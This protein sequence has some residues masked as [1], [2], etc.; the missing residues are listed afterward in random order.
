MEQHVIRQIRKRDGRLVAFDEQKI[1]NAIYRAMSITGMN[2]LGQAQA[3]AKRVCNI[4]KAV[5]KSDKVPTVESVQDIVETTLMDEGFL[6]VAKRYII[7]RE[8]HQKMRSTE[9]LL[10]SANEL[11][12]NYLIK[13]DWRIKENSNMSYS[14]QGLNNHI[15]AILVSK[16]WLQEIYSEKVRQAHERGDLH[17]HDL[18]SLSG[19]CCGWD[20]RDLLLKG[21]RGA[22]GKTE[23]KPAKHF[24][25]ALGQVCNFFFT[26]QGEAA[27]AQAFSNF[28]TYLAPFIAYDGLTYQEVLQCMQEFIFNVNVPTRGGFQTPFTNITLDLHV[29][30]NMADEPVIIGGQPQERTFKEFQVEMDMLNRA[31]CQV[32]MRGDAQGRIFTF[33]IPTYNLTKNFDWEAPIVEDIFKMTAKYGIPYFANFINSDMD[34]EDARSMCCRL[35]LDNRELRKRGGGLF[36]ANPLTGS[37]GVVTLNLPRAAYLSRSKEEFYTRILNLMDVAKESL[38]IKRKILER[39]TENNLYPYSKYYLSG[40]KKQKGAYWANHFSTIG[41]NGMQEA[42]LNLIG[43][44]V[45][46]VEGRE[47]ALETLDIM[48]KRLQ[49]YQEEEGELYNLE[50]TPGEGTAYRFARLD[51]KEY[52]DIITSG[53]EEPYYTNSTQLPVDATTDVFEALENQDELQ[54]KYTGGTVLHIF[55]GESIDDIGTCKT[56]VRKVAEN[57]TLPYFTITPTFSICPVHGYIRGEHHVCPEA[58][59]HDG[60]EEF[61]IADSE[62]LV[63]NELAAHAV[64]LKD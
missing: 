1:I 53:E 63:K 7:Y 30:R 29:P 34:P 14:L 47:L 38:K 60:Q 8:Q 43:K 5:Y 31:F 18:G 50:A 23:S 10:S 24:R 33:P 17:L 45:D 61:E 37:L 32:M 27:G 2:D 28:D 22:Y 39:Y 20:L 52:P 64:H 4:L 9:Q 11:I 26:L 57:Y 51:K 12:D 40:V 25:T 59:E 41:L 49:E 62:P 3:V 58:R 21:I 55:L 54:A 42:A 13:N 36:G 16:Y 15:T 46:T 48:R 56:L 6:E 44:G 19:Y 35:R